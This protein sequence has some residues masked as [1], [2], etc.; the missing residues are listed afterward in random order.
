MNYG[1]GLNPSGANT[2][3]AFLVLLSN[4]L[5]MKFFSVGRQLAGFRYLSAFL[6]APL[7]PTPATLTATATIT[8]T[9]GRITT[10]I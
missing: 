5:L 2:L 7:T 3:S 9:R 10:P 1:K 6:Q 4:S 8:V